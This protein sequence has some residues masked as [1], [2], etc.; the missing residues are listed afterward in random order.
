MAPAP[1][2]AEVAADSGGARI[3]LYFDEE[4]IPDG[5]SGGGYAHPEAFTVTAGGAARAVEFVVLTFSGG[6]NSIRIDLAAGHGIRHGEAVTLSYTPPGPDDQGRPA[7]PLAD[8]AGNEVAGFATGAGEVPAVAN[9]LP[10]GPPEAPGGL[11]AEGGGTKATLTWSAPFDGG[12]PIARYRVRW[13]KGNSPSGA[14]QD[15]EDSGP[16]TERH[17]VSGLEAGAQYTLQVRAVNVHGDGAEATVTLTLEAD[18]IPPAPAGA[19]VGAGGLFVTLAF[20]ED[21]DA[22]SI[23]AA[24][25]FDVTV[26]GNP[27]TPT[28]AAVLDE[29]AEL[30]LTLPRAVRPGEAVRVA[31]RPPT[32]AQAD[33]G[34]LALADAAGNPVAA[35]AGLQADNRLP[36]TAPAAPE[37]LR[38]DETGAGGEVTLAWRAPH[39]NGSAITKYRLRHA[40]GTGAGGTWEDIPMS[41]PGQDNAGRWTVTGL[42]DGTAYTFQVLAVNAEGEGAPATLTA[43]PEDKTAPRVVAAEVDK[44][45]N[46]PVIALTFDEAPN[47]GS[48]FRTINSVY[49][50]NRLA[51]T[52]TAGGK[53]LTPAALSTVSVTE[54]VLWMAEGDIRPG[55]TVTVTYTPPTGQGAE[56]LRDLAGNEVAAFTTGQDGTPGVE[57]TL[58][59]AKPGAPEDLEAAA[60]AFAGAMVL[61]WTPAWHNGSAIARYELRTAPGEAVPADVGWEAIEPRAGAGGSLRHTATGLARGRSHSFELRAVN[62]KGTGP[63]A[64]VTGRGLDDAGPRAVAG[65]VPLQD[66]TFVQIDFDEPLDRDAAPGETAFAVTVRA[67]GAVRTVAPQTAAPHANADA[68]FYL[69]LAPADAI[70]PGEEVTVTYVPP[71]DPGAARLQDLAGNPAP[72]FVT[73]AGGV[74][75]VRNGLNA[76][77]P[78]A[79]GGLA[80][81]AGTEDGSAVLTWTAPWANGSAIVKYQLR[82]A[83]GQVAGGS[84]QDIPDSAPGTRGPGTEDGDGT[85]TGA[86]ANAASFTV[87]G[88]D[89][90]QAYTFQLRA[91][92]RARTNDGEGAPATAALAA[93]PLP[94]LLSAAIAAGGPR[95]ATLTWDEALDTESVPAAAA[96]ALT[97]DGR[98]RAVGGV[99]IPENS[100]RTVELAL[101]A[102]VRP[103]QSVTVRYDPAQAGT[104]TGTGPLQDTAG[105]QAAA[106]AGRAVANALAATAPEAPADF[107]ADAV[108][109]TAVLTWRTPHDGGSAITGYEMRY[110]AGGSAPTGS[111]SPVPRSRAGA[112]RHTVGGLAPGGRH[113]F[114]IRALNATG[115]NGAR[116]PTATA[117][118]DS[119]VSLREAAIT[120]QAGAAQVRL[121]FGSVLDRSATPDKAAFTVTAGGRQRALTGVALPGG[122]LVTLNLVAADAVRPGETVTVTYRKPDTNPLQSLAGKQ[123]PPFADAAVDNQLTQGGPAKPGGLA[124]A[125]P[126]GAA[127]AVSLTWTTPWHNGSPIAGYQVRF[128]AGGTVPGA[129]AWTAIGGSGPGTVQHTVTGLADATQYA[130][131]VRAL[132]G[133]SDNRV[134]GAASDTAT[135]TTAAAD[136]APNPTG[137]AIAAGNASEIVLTFD[138]GL[139]AHA[140]PAACTVT[141]QGTGQ[142]RRGR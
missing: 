52:V 40:A 30:V 68:S 7:R 136:G 25:A 94:N 101:E 3:L 132:N 13:Q 90:G 4:A 61:T 58:P 115:A 63:E 59:A 10:P 93:D 45:G 8:L 14:W 97:V 32:G 64:A 24:G 27:L 73:G 139:S 137:A 18:S 62:A 141:V 50:Q 124:A 142:G 54:H 128:A 16:E 111:W 108:F 104:G 31:Y 118:S 29:P 102:P 60:G 91:V 49:R 46:Q 81:R 69:E 87:A 48:F 83:R 80:V 98:A 119:A 53:A 38:A 112:V 78:E 22:D 43:T 39:D 37:G 88:L 129:T 84:W 6:G 125:A 116:G 66:G 109:D 67:G 113:T 127:G 17:A 57:N 23:A 126:D 11:A 106:F 120:I 20:D 89:D 41:A 107:R 122:E 135:A 85:V 55:D 42:T 138:E 5:Y 36:A 79:P 70:R 123:A 133:P 99:E 77:P 75:A 82:Y 21:L 71:A 76:T 117:T 95:L 130:F 86:G 131:Q 96:F 33:A 100:P 65:T 35:F 15:I 103:G 56:P 51:F 19:E 9:N 12:A 2:G 105:E 110:A 28:G 92:N 72:G 74:P 121:T 44:S 114:Q 1:V 47:T 140:N 134:G 34:A 26:A